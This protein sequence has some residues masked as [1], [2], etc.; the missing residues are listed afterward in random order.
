MTQEKKRPNL[1]LH[2]FILIS[3]GIHVLIFLHVAG[4]YESRAI[5]YIE[6]S[7]H[8]ISKPNVRVIPKPRMREKAPKVS[9]EKTVQ[10]KKFHVPKIKIDA[11]ED[12]KTDQSYERISLPQLPE[13]M[14]AAG[15]SVP[16]LKIQSQVAEVPV[17][18]EYVEFTSAREYFEMLILR[19]DYFK[20]YPES[21]RSRYIQGRVK[22]E[23]VLNKDGSL[24]GIKIIKSSRHKNLDQA[25]LEAVSKA[26]PFPRPPLYIFN[27]PV[28]LQ[29]SILFELA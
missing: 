19:I 8:Q 2:G 29:I 22:V 10:V 11:V 28:R 5:S 20:N 9:V 17:H 13:H 3:L 18:E 6:L 27:P 26:S 14:N 25:A 24:S 7:M 4:I 1:L 23:F 21:A 16:D 12:Y 15:F